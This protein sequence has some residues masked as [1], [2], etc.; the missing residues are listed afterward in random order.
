MQLHRE[1]MVRVAYVVTGDLD[2]ARCRCGR[3]AGGLDMGGAGAWAGIYE[4]AYPP[5]PLLRP[6]SPAPSPP[7]PDGG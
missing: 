4:A 7:A 3:V 5:L 2:L 1:A 6:G